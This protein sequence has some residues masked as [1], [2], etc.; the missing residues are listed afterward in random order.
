MAS[1]ST[2]LRR[3][4]KC[5]FCQLRNVTTDNTCIV[6]LSFR[7]KLGCRLVSP[8]SARA[9]QLRTLQCWA[10]KTDPTVNNRFP[11]VARYAR[12]P[13]WA[14]DIYW[15]HRTTQVLPR[16]IIM[17]LIRAGKP[18][19]AG[20]LHCCTYQTPQFQPDGRYVSLFTEGWI[21][22]SLSSVGDAM[23]MPIRYHIPIQ[24]VLKEESSS[25]QEA[26]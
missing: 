4:V 17:H 10:S 25:W 8:P 22:I 7:I 12:K 15:D 14:N 16:F 26:A 24:F 5:N 23:I 20:W 11:K 9:L 13:A 6:R 21:R 18:L 1:R 3:L 2:H 19:L